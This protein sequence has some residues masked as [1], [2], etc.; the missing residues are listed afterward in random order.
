[1]KRGDIKMY[2]KLLLTFI[3]CAVEFKGGLGNNNKGATRRRRRPQYL[4]A[5]SSR[6]IRR[7]KV[8]AKLKYIAPTRRYLT[9]IIDETAAKEAASI[10][11][12]SNIDERQMSTNTILTIS[13]DSFITFGKNKSSLIDCKNSISTDFGAVSGC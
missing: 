10:P 6:I 8:P 9:D 4:G 3:I 11:R 12:Y 1:M 2:S 7:K 5:V 13:P